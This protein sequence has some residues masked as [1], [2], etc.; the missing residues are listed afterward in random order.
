MP[1]PEAGQVLVKVHACGVC[2]SDVGRIMKGGAYHY[3]LVPGH[4]FAGTVAETGEGVTGAKTGDRVSVFP[5]LPCG[6]CGSCKEGRY[7]LCSHYDYFGSRRDGGFEEYVAVP[8][9]NLVHLPDE[10][11]L[12]V[13][14]MCEPVAV[15]LH[16][17]RRGQVALGDTV[18]V[19][20][21]GPIGLVLSRLAVLAG[22][23]RVVV[24]D[25]DPEKVAFSRQMGNDLTFD[26]RDTDVGAA[27]EQ[28]L[29]RRLDLVIEGTGASAG[30]AAC[31]SALRQR[32]RLV[33]MG[34]PGGDMKLEKSVYSQILRKEITLS[35]TW[36]SD[37]LSGIRDDWE[38][39]VDLLARDHAWFDRLISHRFR[40]ED[41]RRPLDIMTE[42]KEF[43]CKTMYVMGDDQ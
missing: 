4:K 18:G 7:N 12:E 32:G 37:H 41:E 35:G 19:A 23:K 42:R 28:A 26:S 11:P 8:E 30:L 2:G 39:V 10:V 24:W 25:I 31:V 13:A 38:T 3:P 5:M 27:A 40:L 33:L 17:I 20:G 43:F 29:G 36:N 22:A 14:A 1:R 21:A 9:W 15:A 34:N 6:E 16:A